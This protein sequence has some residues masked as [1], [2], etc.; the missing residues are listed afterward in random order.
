MAIPAQNIKY[1]GAGPSASG[2]VVLQ[3]DMNGQL[4]K[5]AFGN[6]T[7]TGD[8]ST[9]TAVV[10][11]IDGTNTRVAVPSGLIATICGG[12]DTA[13]VLKC[14]K[15]NGDLKTATVTFSTAIASAATCQLALCLLP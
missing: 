7:F 8:G 10:N 15:D 9:T 2:Q 14:V 11:Y 3:Q 12:T 5:I 4:A 6:V 1:I 13:A